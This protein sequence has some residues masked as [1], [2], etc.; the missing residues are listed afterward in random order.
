MFTLHVQN[1]VSILKV[2]IEIGLVKANIWMLFLNTLIHNFKTLTNF[3]E[4]KDITKVCRSFRVVK[5][6]VDFR[7]RRKSSPFPKPITYTTA[8]T[9]GCQ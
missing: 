5:D 7:N 9:D 6:C 4:F 1:S 8:V 2:V 3:R